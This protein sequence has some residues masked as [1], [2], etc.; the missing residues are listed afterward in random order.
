MVGIDPIV[1]WTGIDL[2]LTTDK[3][4]TLGSGNIS[5]I[6]SGKIGSRA[7]FAVKWNHD[8]PVDQVAHKAVVFFL[9]TITPVNI[10]GFEK[11]LLRSDP[12]DEFHVGGRGRIVVDGGFFGMR[13]L[14]E[15]G[16]GRDG[17]GVAGKEGLSGQWFGDGTQ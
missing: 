6:S 1:R 7:K 11:G 13:V 4:G 12:V 9:R 15:S 14:M 5:R 16:G 8:T 10:V 2:L 17:G 3:S